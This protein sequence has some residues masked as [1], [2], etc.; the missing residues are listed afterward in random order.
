M[1]RVKKIKLGK[2]R[3]TAV[4]LRLVDKT[5]I[6]IR[7]AKGYIMCGYLNLKAAAKFKDA[8]IKVT[9][10]STIEEA[11]K[12]R[13]Y[14]CTPAAKRLGVRKGQAINQALKLIA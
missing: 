14:A 8:A 13:V 5:L 3:L 12:T 4:S 9:G 6:V 2:K 7:G 11:L 10:I 1:V